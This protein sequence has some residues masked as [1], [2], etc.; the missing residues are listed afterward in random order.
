MSST[1]IVVELLSPLPRITDEET[2]RLWEVA[3][4]GDRDAID[5]LIRTNLRLIYKLVLRYTAVVALEAD[6]D[7]VQEA[8]VGFIDAIKSYNPAKASFRTHAV[9]RIREQL[10]S[11]TRKA[12][13]EW[14]CLSLDEPT[15]R[16]PEC[17]VGC[18]RIDSLDSESPDPLDT[19]LDMELTSKLYE[20]IANALSAEQQHTLVQYYGLDGRKPISGPKLAKDL[21]VTPQ[22]ISWRRLQ[23]LSA[24]KQYLGS[25]GLEDEM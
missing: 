14:T 11:V 23:A 22:A 12:V 1:N 19:C 21:G 18:R 13:R 15:L 10:R 3:K 20:A 8:I 4:R 25:R 9:W 2:L 7:L 5:R 24:L 6:K 16:T 17:I